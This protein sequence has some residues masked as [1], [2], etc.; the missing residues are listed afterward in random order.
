[1]QTLRIIYKKTSSLK[2]NSRNARTHTRGQINQIKSSIEAFGFSN[3][4]LANGEGLIIA[5]HARQAAAIE[6]QLETVPVIELN[7]LNEVEMRALMLADNKIALNAGWDEELLAIELADLSSLELNFDVGLTG[8]DTGEIDL[9]ISNYELDPESE[10]EFAPGLD[11]ALPAVTKVGDLWQ[12]GAHRLICGDAKNKDDLDKLMEG[13][14]A[15]AGFTDPPYNV[16]I[17]GHVSGK[18]KTQHREFTEGAGEMS[19]AEFTQFLTDAFKLASAVSNDGAVWFAC[20]DWR[21]LLEIQ[22]AGLNTFGSLL[23]LCVWAKTNGGMGSL[24]RSQHELVF[25][26]RNGKTQHRNNVQLG[27]F[28]RNRTNLWRYPGVNTFKQGRMSELTAHPTAK[29]VAMIKDAL[30]DVTK[31]GAIV[32]DPFMGA[33]AS[34]MASEASGR[35][36]YGLEIDPL[37]VDVALRRWR[38]LSGIEP[39]NTKTGL[40]LCD[41]EEIAMKEL[42]E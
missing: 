32:L 10:P 34:L 3:P 7:D 6:L 15:D 21:H 42:S 9:I 4:I 40:A 5:G 13:K 22:E 33:G 29:P 37:Y 2:A 18:G 24:Y 35:I 28:G 36:A 20:M 11:S 1:M 14:L 38:A 41:L 30:M 31:R 19:K 26:F 17:K 8:F 27:R 25:V 23:N 39:I 16:P 12:L